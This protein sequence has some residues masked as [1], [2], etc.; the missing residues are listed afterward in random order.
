MASTNVKRLGAVL[1]TV[2]ARETAPWEDHPHRMTKGTVS[3]CRAAL[4]VIYVLMTTMKTSC[5]IL[6]P[7]T[8]T[9][10][11]HGGQ[12]KDVGTIYI[13]YFRWQ[14][15]CKKPAT[16]AK[17]TT[18]QRPHPHHD[19]S[20]ALVTAVAAAGVAA[21]AASVPTPCA[22]TSASNLADPPE[23]T[24]LFQ[25]GPL[26]ASLPDQPWQPHRHQQA[27][28]PPTPT[29]PTQDDL[30]STVQCCCRRHCCCCCC[31]C[32]RRR[33]VCQRTASISCVRVPV[34]AHL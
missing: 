31:C 24:P 20:P 2:S 34:P 14:R 4:M 12:P 25:M 5:S 13:S 8:Y 9:S 15:K 1:P 33:G 28:P 6:Q 21:A 10:H 29:L 26:A 30:P 22:A 7:L 11:S 17:V 19:M 23:F 16:T 27:P 3:Y 18:S 32:C